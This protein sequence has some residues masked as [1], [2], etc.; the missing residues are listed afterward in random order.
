VAEGV[1]GKGLDRDSEYPRP[2]SVSSRA[3]V[4]R[5]DLG[6]LPKSEYQK[7]CTMAWSI[8]R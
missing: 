8:T 6:R 7:L 4:V 3:A 1:N 2:E 5:S